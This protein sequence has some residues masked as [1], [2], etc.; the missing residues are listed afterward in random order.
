VLDAVSS[1]LRERGVTVHDFGHLAEIPAFDPGANDSTA[2]VELRSLIASN[3]VIV[4]AS[5]EYAGGMAGALKNALDWIV[6]SGE[7]YE[8]PVAV[9][10]AG[11]TGGPNA[12]HQLVRTLTWQGAFVIEELGVAAPRKK[13]NDD[14]IVT[15]G[16]TV[17]DLRAFAGLTIKKA[18]LS[19]EMQRREATAVASRQGIE[20]RS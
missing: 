1:N 12:R 16:E 14:G 19:P 3:D 5:P 18:S 6:G 2:V 8:R 17:A 13:I 11:T 9:V 7:F 20:S 4:I 10:S 15:D